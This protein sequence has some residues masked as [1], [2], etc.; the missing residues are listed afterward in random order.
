MLALPQLAGG[1]ELDEVLQQGATP[2]DLEAAVMHA[3]VAAAAPAPGGGAS[4]EAA[5]GPC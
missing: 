4:A 1:L 5:F 3:A 2:A